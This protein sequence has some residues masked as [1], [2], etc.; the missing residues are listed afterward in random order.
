MAIQLINGIKVRTTYEYPP[1]P[2]RSMDWS[3]IDDDNYDADCDQDG[4]FSTSPIGRGPTEEAAIADL[5]EQI[6]EASEVS[7]DRSK[8]DATEVV[9]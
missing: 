7:G 9:R 8:A 5:M 3:A 1:I 4:F 2:D 6:A